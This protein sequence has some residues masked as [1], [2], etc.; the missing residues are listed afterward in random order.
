MRALSAASSIVHRML[1]ACGVVVF[2][3]A[4]VHRSSAADDAALALFDKGEYI[5]AADAAVAEGS[6]AGFALAARATLA[7]ATLRDMPCF[8]CLQRAEALARK[9]IATDP[10]N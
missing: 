6:S 10:N 7:D 1:L 9:A 4:G 3:V 5:A 2:V 8:D